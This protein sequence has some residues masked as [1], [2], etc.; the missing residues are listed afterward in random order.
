[1]WTSRFWKETM[2]RAVKTLAQSLLAIWGADSLNIWTVD[3]RSSVGVA[4][5]AG[6]LSV[7]TSLASAGVKHDD[8]PS[9]V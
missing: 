7:L 4:V 2:E 6:V 3:L 5:G 8:S 9:L 1:M